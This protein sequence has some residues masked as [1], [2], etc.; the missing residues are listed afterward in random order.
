MSSI[1]LRLLSDSVFLIRG[2]SPGNGPLGKE[3]R[4]YAV[5]PFRLSNRAATRG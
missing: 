3:V 2:L 4:R 5:L 1:L